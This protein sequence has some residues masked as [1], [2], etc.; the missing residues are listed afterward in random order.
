MTQTDPEHLLV[1]F[2]QELGE[3]RTGMLGLVE[4]EGHAQPM[5]AHFEG[6]HGPLWFYAHSH[7]VLVRGCERGCAAVFHYI[8]PGHDL[9]ACVHGEV[10]PCA[11]E[12]M[13]GRFWSEEVARWYPRG[14]SDPDLALLRFVPSSAQIWLPSD[15]AQ[16]QLFGLDEHRAPPRDIHAEVRL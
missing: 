2:W 16:P 12:N 9:Y 3:L 11:E 8:G 7:S 14:R 6:Q 4:Q 5:T 15:G 13:V 1:R 10:A